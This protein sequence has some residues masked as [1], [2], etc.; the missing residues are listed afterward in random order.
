MKNK[1][2]KIKRLTIDI[3]ERFHK[4]LKL[5]ALKRNVTMRTISIRALIKYLEQED[6]F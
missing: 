5:A 1:D 2:I 3:D 6:K 4:K